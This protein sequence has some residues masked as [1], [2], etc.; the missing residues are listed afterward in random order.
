MAGFVP[1]GEDADDP[2]QIYQQILKN[3]LKF[4]KHMKNEK[5]N[6]FITLLLNKNPET[7][8]GGSFT[9]LKKHAAFEKISWVL[10]I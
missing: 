5:V 9:N 2:L 7:R 8:M 6:N 4:P 3:P 1:F 10:F